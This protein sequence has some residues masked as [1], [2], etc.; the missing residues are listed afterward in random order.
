[1]TTENEP[2]KLIGAKAAGDLV[3]MKPITLWRWEKQG[4]FPKSIKLDNGRKFYLSSDVTAWI[5]DQIKA[6]RGA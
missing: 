6:A 1:M 2:H 5:S 3:G 4:R